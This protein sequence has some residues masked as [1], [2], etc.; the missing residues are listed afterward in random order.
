MKSKNEQAVELAE[1]IHEQALKEDEIF[2]LNAIAANK[3]TQADGE[4]GMVYH[5][6]NLLNLL[7]EIEANDDKC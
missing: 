2:K 3:A 4:S 1:Y 6:R 7:K 5:T